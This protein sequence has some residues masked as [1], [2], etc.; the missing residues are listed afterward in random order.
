MKVNIAYNNSL[1]LK[2]SGLSLLYLTGE[3]VNGVACEIVEY[4]SRGNG[5][6][7][8]HSYGKAPPSFIF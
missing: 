1:N 6:I 5:L 7:S 2:Q 8:M 3:G 4:E